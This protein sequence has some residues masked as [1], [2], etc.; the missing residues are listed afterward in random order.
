MSKKVGVNS[1]CCR[2]GKK[3]GMVGTVEKLYDVFVLYIDNIG[4]KGV[5]IQLSQ[6]ELLFRPQ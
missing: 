2:G 4:W 1:G 3:D 6:P 5:S